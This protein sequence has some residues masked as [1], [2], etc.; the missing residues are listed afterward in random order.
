MDVL[1]RVFDTADFPP[2]WSCGSW[3]AA[4]GWLHIIADSLIFLAYFAIPVSLAVLLV[5][6]RDFP[7]PLILALFS[8]FILFCGIGHLLEAVIFYVPIYRVAGLWKAG[9]ATVSLVTAAVL[10][11]SLPN[12][13]SLPSIRRANEDLSHSLAREQSLTA[14]LTATRDQLEAHTAKMTS[15]S[16]RLTSAVEAAR[17]VACRWTLPDG[18]IDWE[19]GF[20]EG[21]RR[22]GLPATTPFRNW[23][24]ILDNRV[25][26]ELH[27]AWEVGFERGEQVDTE[28]PV[29]GAPGWHVLISATPEP[30]VNGERRAM[31]G[32]FRF[33]PR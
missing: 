19:I 17:A 8:A 25:L 23:S 28:A 33:F 26:S 15:R 20:A 2:R 14:A 29:L 10:I 22:A 31:I 4:H 21:A 12:A 30:P 7:F 6:R 9:T 16:W 18:L 1:A 11:K 13:L 5:R 27:R 3:S 32:I 24:D